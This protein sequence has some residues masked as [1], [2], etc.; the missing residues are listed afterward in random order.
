M[1]IPTVAEADKLLNEAEKLN[2]GRWVDKLLNEAEKLNP[3][4]WVAHS[5]TAALC[6]RAVAEKCENLNPDCAYVLGLLH[7]IGRRQGVT[8][9]KCIFCSYKFMFLKVIILQSLKEFA[10]AVKRFANF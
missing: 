3:G 2:P 8:G 10:L 1:K 6:A 7:D 4:R 5:R 9:M